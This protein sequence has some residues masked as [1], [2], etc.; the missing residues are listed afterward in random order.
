MANPIDLISRT[1]V[2]KNDVLI[3]NK[4]GKLQI[5]ASP[6]AKMA[7]VAELIRVHGN[8]LDIQFLSKNEFETHKANHYHEK[9]EST[10]TKGLEADID[11]NDAANEFNERAEISY[12]EEN[13]EIIVFV[14]AIFSQAV[15]KQANDIALESTADKLVIRFVIDGRYKDIT[16][17]PI[18]VAQAIIARIKIMAKLDTFVKKMPQDGAVTM[19][20]LGRPFDTRISTLP[21]IFGERVSIRLLPADDMQKDIEDLGLSDSERKKF[22]YLMT[23]PKGVVLLAGPT[24]SGKTT[25]MYAGIKML[26]TPDKSIITIENPVE[27]RMKGTGIVQTQVSP[28]AGYTFAKAL[29]SVVRQY[30]NVI[31]LGEI[32]DNETADFA[33]QSSTTG[34]LTLSS[35]HTNSAV[36]TISRLVKMQV[37]RHYISSSLQGVISQRLIRLLCPHCKEEHK[38]T[39]DLA[40]K[41]EGLLDEGAH[42]YTHKGCLECEFEGYKGRVAIYEFLIMNNEI[43][44][45][46]NAN[47]NELDIEKA[48]IAKGESLIEKGFIKVGHGVT[49]IDEILRVVDVSEAMVN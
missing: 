15:K 42:H 24:G 38:V 40:K 3:A 35:I 43:R 36:G 49:S 48:A 21:S 20:F 18:G 9:G 34:H 22:E 10:L 37:E 26:N 46:I 41:F 16:S 11:L 32:R 23:R 13:S 12:S 8:K 5:I 31:L 4:D 6:D 33:L 45:L 30:P 25:S 28:E 7:A 27:Y 44:A 19:S 39:P 29:R 47:V 2:E 1:F 14:N 17:V